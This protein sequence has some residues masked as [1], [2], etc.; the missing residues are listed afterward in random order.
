MAQQQLRRFRVYRAAIGRPD[1]AY[2]KARED[3][4]VI[5]ATDELRALDELAAQLDVTRVRRTRSV[6][7]LGVG[8]LKVEAI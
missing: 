4:G 6:A 8:S 2:Y 5:V 1:C 3:Y 7:V